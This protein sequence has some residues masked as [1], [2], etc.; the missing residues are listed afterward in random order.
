MPFRNSQ[1]TCQSLIHCSTYTVPQS[2]APDTSKQPSLPHLGIRRHNDY[3]MATQVTLSSQEAGG[4]WKPASITCFQ[5]EQ[6]SLCNWITFQDLFNLW[7]S[8]CEVFLLLFLFTRDDCNLCL[9]IFFSQIC[10][11]SFCFQM[12]QNPGGTQGQS[13]APL[14]VIP[15][16]IFCPFYCILICSPS[17]CFGAERK[18]G[19]SVT[20]H[21]FLKL[22]NLW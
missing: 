22:S 8:P 4:L 16:A 1:V 19:K 10:L 6:R 18:T 14:M 11:P 15:F 21:T 7:P 13:F 2:P 5:R 17:R 12:T 9:E 3:K 20:T